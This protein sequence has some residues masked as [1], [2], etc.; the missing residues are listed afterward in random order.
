MMQPAPAEPG[1]PLD[2]VD[3]PALLL[4]LDAFEANLR[5]MADSVAGTGVKLRPH[6]KTHKC[7]TIALKQIEL[8]AV[9]QCC[10]KVGEAEALVRGG[11]RDILVSNEIVGAPKLRR[12]AALSKQATIAVCAD[13]PAQVEAYAA[14]AVEAG[15]TLTVL[16]EINVGANRCGVEPGAP[17]RDL[18][19][20]IE[21][22]KGLSFGG[23]QAYHGSAQHLRTYEERQ[24]AIAGAVAAAAETRDMLA[25]D[26]LD[27]AIIGGAG[28]GSY[29]FEAGSGVYNE[30][31][32]GSYVFMDGDYARNQDRNGGPY[33]R[34]QHA[35]FIWAAAISRG[36]PERGVLDAGH[37]ATSIDSGLPTAYGRQDIDVVGMSDEHTKLKLA[38]DSPLKVGDKLRL[39]PGH[40]DPTVNL[41]DWY[42]CYRG[43]RVECLWPI[44]A[45]GAIY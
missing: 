22:A 16:V 39:V 6:A 41:H 9:G 2:A 27:C 40:C 36:N 38:P 34:F 3:T 1:M 37:K 10:Q 8:G 30:L 45:A 20:L 18:A 17:A 7:P 32:V 21:G 24:A 12:L 26:G 44:A 28:T 25:K 14:A 5:T 42:V 19:R 15:T 43:D 13:D 4:D 29:E 23:L 11:V 31:Q 35:L 33:Q